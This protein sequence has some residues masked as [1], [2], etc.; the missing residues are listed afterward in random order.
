MV[1][2]PN[3][4]VAII[5]GHR[6]KCL[7]D[8]GAQITTISKACSGKYLS[9]LP[10]HSI[11]ELLWVECANG[12]E[13]PYLG[14]VEVAITLPGSLPTEFKLYAPVLI[15]PDTPYNQ[16]VPCCVGTNVIQLCVKQGREEFGQNFADSNEIAPVWHLAYTSMQTPFTPDR[17][18]K[19]GPA[20]IASKRAIKVPANAAIIVDCHVP[21]PK[22]RDKYEVMLELQ[23]TL[24]P[25]VI[26]NPGTLVVDEEMQCMMR[27]VFQYW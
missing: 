6:C 5:D 10:L 12:Q 7:V 19:V 1:R 4:A 21:L 3:E 8:T 22:A 27:V 11:G 26:V 16:R 13:I 23:H 14:Y 24:Q 17:N 15:V 9:Q 18:G 2:K 20:I 25:G